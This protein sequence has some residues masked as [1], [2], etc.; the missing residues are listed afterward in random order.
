MALVGVLSQ[1]YFLVLSVIS[2]TASGEEKVLWLRCRYT[3]LFFSAALI[4]AI[5]IR[6]KRNVLLVLTVGEF[7]SEK[8]D[9]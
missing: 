3:S 6:A 7:T 4:L 9:S 2:G 5:L 8:V 1:T